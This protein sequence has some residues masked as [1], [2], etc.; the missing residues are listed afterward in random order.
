M[1][2][3]TRLLCEWSM[4]IKTCSDAFRFSGVMP[5][6]ARSTPDLITP[7]SVHPAFKPVRRSNGVDIDDWVAELEQDGEWRAALAEGRQWVADTFY[8][9]E[10][11]TV[12]ALRLRKGLS[13]AGLA[14]LM[15]TSQSHIARIERGREDVALSTLRRL[16]D[17][18][19]VTLDAL[20]QALRRQTALA[21]AKSGAKG[22]ARPP[23]KAR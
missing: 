5:N 12:C 23:R 22:R 16:S 8:A 21:R 18:L 13:Q 4:P 15:G 17:A 2:Q 9:G 6:R 3:A 14:A 19:G 20:D 11:D 10:G 7:I 1:T